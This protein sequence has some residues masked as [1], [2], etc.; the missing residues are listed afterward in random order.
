VPIYR[1]VKDAKPE[2][3]YYETTAPVCYKG[4]LLIGSSGADN[5]VRGFFMG[6][7]AKDLSPA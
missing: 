2:F 3:G 4:I 1:D 5:G 7:N 6:Y